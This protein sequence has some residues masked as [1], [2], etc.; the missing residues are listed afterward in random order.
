MPVDRKPW[1]QM[2]KTPKQGFWLS[3]AN[4]LLAVTGWV[5]VAV[6]ADDMLLA[7]I[8]ASGWSLLAAAFLASSVALRRRSK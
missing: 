4:A 8:V 1:W 7:L 3:G 5:R 2:T 6:T